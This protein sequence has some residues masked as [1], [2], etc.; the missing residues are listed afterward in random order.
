MRRNSEIT[1]RQSVGPQA[2]SRRWT[3]WRER[4]LILFALPLAMVANIYAYAR[5]QKGWPAQVG[6]FFVFIPV[7][8]ITS[9]IW[10]GAWAV[11]IGIGLHLIAR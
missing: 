1:E 10:F 9:A 4:L 7:I 8:V 3:R 11:A 5:L 6:M 2:P